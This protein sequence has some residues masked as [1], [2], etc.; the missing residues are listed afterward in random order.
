MGAPTAWTVYNKFKL[1]VGNKLENLGSDTIKMA[2][3]T[4][5]SRYIIL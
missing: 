5:A 2:L 4:S 3:F 1:N